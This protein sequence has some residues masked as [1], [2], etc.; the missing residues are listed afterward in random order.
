MR[1]AEFCVEIA[2]SVRAAEDIISL[3]I[4][5]GDLRSSLPEAGW[6]R[7]STFVVMHHVMSVLS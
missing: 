7:Y 6:R 3:S 2:C 1:Y 5:I 4:S